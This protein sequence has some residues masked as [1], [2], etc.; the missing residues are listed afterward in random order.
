MSKKNRGLG[1]ERMQQ[2]R[3]SVAAKRQRRELI[4]SLGDTDMDWLGFDT[5]EDIVEY[6]DRSLREGRAA[7]WID[8]LG[9][10]SALTENI[11]RYRKPL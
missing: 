4:E 11:N 3:E 7:E 10:R 6:V 5:V 2:L 1:P 8:R 9:S